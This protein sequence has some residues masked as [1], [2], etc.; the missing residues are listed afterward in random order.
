MYA[1]QE[2]REYDA[3][4]TRV[5]HHYGP[6][7]EIGGYNSHDLMKLRGLDAKREVAEAEARASRPL[8]EA[9]TR[10]HKTRERVQRAWRTITDGQA[11]LAKNRRVH[12]INGAT[13]EM[14]EPVELPKWDGRTP[15]TVAEYD[16]ANAETSVMA[17]EMEAR[18]SKIASYV[19][20][21]ERSTMDE[22]NR[23]LILALADRLDRLEAK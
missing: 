14:L 15:A 6:S 23:S 19:S 18:A 4:V 20:V 1:N 9:G 12:A 3:L 22:Q 5:R 8:M 21:W 17:T 7:V 2:K 16:T 11:T 13:A 10:L